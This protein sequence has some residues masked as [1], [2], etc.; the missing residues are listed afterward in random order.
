MASCAGAN[1]VGRAASGGGCLG[2]L[3]LLSALACGFFSPPSAEARSAAPRSARLTRLRQAVSNSS[4]SLGLLPP[5]YHTT[6]DI[7]SQ[8]HDLSKRCPGLTVETVSKGS[9][10][11]PATSIEVATIRSADSKPVN[12]M[13]MLFGEHSRELISPET[14]L[15]FVKSLCG[16]TGFAEQA[17]EE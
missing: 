2:R 13:F 15:H 12:R 14:G 5:F 7:R 11:S 17:K 1:M 16:E 8:L 10:L 9:L 3:L 4:S 6:E